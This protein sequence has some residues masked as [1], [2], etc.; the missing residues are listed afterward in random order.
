MQYLTDLGNR[1]KAW[2]DEER[3]DKES[4]DP[5]IA[6]ALK[7]ATTAMTALGEAIEKRYQQIDVD[8]K[9]PAVYAAYQTKLKAY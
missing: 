7:N 6:D 9:D 3:R 4:S 1:L 5:G 8:L 2:R